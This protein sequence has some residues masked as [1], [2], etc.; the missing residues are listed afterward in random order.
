MKHTLIIFHFIIIF[1]LLPT[2]VMGD[3]MYSCDASETNWII[4]FKAKKIT[5]TGNKG[6]FVCG[7]TTENLVELEFIK[8]EKGNDNYPFSKGWKHTYDEYKWEQNGCKYTAP[9]SFYQ[10]KSY[11]LYFN[12][13]GHP[14]VPQCCN[15][16]NLIEI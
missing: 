8:K 4:H 7:S 3:Q 1:I 14:P 11:K 10:G 12:I 16:T 5:T 15:C 13:K 9:D 6:K 2:K